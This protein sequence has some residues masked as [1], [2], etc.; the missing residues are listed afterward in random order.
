MTLISRP[1]SH[2]QAAWAVLDAGHAR[3]IAL[4]LDD[5]R[6]VLDWLASGDAPPSAARQAAAVLGDADSPYDLPGLA[7]AVGETAG[8][9]RLAARDALAHIPEIP[10]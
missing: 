8:R 3:D 9:L 5:A 2:E 7:S 10:S 4:M 6:T 1:G